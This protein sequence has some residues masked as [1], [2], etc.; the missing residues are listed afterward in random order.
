MRGD[1]TVSDRPIDSAPTRT[2]RPV[3]SARSVLPLGRSMTDRRGGFMAGFT[4]IELMV[5]IAV[6]ATLAALGFP[7]LNFIRKKANRQATESLVQSV[8]TAIASYPIRQWTFTDSATNKT[9]TR[10]LWDMNKAGAAATDLMK[11]DRMIDGYPG[12]APTAGGDVDDPFWDKLIDSGYKGLVRMTQA[13]IPKRSV[14]KRGQVIDAWGQPLYIAFGTEV[15]GP[16]GFGV[17][18]NGPDKKE[19]TADDLTS[20]ASNAE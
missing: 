9:Y 5:V 7:A 4:M 15:Y 13:P 6:I 2:R 10:N 16:S 17:W 3:V 8:A 1:A 19:G 14:N 18:S 12:V 20:W 11:G